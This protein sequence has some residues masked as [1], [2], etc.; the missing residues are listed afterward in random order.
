V[1]RC[2]AAARRDLGADAAVEVDPANAGGVRAACG[3][4]RVDYTL[5]TLADRC[6]DDLGPALRRLWS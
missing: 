3:S 2:C 1:R 4:R 5:P 6:L